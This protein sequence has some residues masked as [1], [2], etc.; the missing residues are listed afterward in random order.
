MQHRFHSACRAFRRAATFVT[1]SVC[2]WSLMSLGTA[3]EAAPAKRNVPKGYGTPGTS[4]TLAAPE[5]WQNAERKSIRAGEIDQLIAA[6]LRNDKIT[7]APLTTDEEFLRRVSLDLTGQLPS[8][9]EVDEFLAD[10]CPDKRAQLIDR[11]L[12][13]EKYARHWAQYWRDV[14]A[15][16]ASVPQPGVRLARDVALETWLFEEFKAN[17]SWSDMARAM[18]TA[19]GTIQLNDPAKSGPVAFLLGHMGPDAPNELAAETARLFLGIQIQCAQCHDH[20]SDIWKRNQFHE[21]A[22]FFGRTRERRNMAAG[23]SV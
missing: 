19:Q 18:I 10:S 8:P 12:D 16:Q 21:L 7:P 4:S 15:A 2:V 22:A 11:L 23:R 6:E 3:E 17:H 14:I 13:S 5:G 9:A 20:P 1:V